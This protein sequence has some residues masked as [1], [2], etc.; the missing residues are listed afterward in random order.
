MKMRWLVGLAVCVA[1]AALPR[2]DAQTPEIQE[3]VKAKLSEAKPAPKSDDKAEGKPLL[4][5]A[6]D[7][8]DFVFVASDRP[9][10]LRLHVR[11]NG[12]P[13][14]TAW[15]DYMKKLFDYFDR[16]GDGKLDKAETERAPN[17][18][19]LQNH[20]QGGIGF[21]Y[22]GQTVR[23]P[24]IDTNKDGKVSPAEFA[25]FYRRG[26]FGPLQFSNSSN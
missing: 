3:A 22:E 12:R 1:L 7:Y 8:K 19:F 5:P 6:I 10:L 13:Y 20:L 25:D 2:A 14:S 4:V 15:D 9:V 23:M 16:N 11:N 21:P 26:G 17:M 18:Q 24:Q